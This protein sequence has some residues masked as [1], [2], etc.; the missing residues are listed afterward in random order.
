MVSLFSPTTAKAVNGASRF[1]QGVSRW[2]AGTDR[3]LRRLRTTAEGINALESAME[4]LSDAALRDKTAEFRDRLADGEALDDLLVEA[5]AV[6]REAGKRTLDQR[7]YDVQLMAGMVL[8]SGKI[9]EMRTGEGKTLVATLP[10]YLN[11]LAGN[12][13]HL[14][15]PNDYLSRI[16]G[17]WMG[18]VYD[19]L[20]ISVGVIAHEF[21]GLYD[22]DFQD[23]QQHGDPRLDHWR[24]VSRQE[25]YAADVTYGTNH[26]F[27]FDYLRDNMVLELS[28]MVQRPLYFAIV[29]EVDNILIDE[30]RT[31]LIISGPAEEPTD[32][33]YK[34]ARVVNSLAED[35][36][37]TVDLKLKAVSLTDEGIDRVEQQ[38]GVDNIYSEDNY[39][40][41]HYLEQAL[42]AKMLFQR[43]KEYVLF[44]DGRVLDGDRRDSNAEVVIVDEFTGRLMQ[45]R[46]Y[47]EGLHQAIE[48]K[49]G[50]RIQRENL[51]LATITFQNY[52]RLYDKLAGMTGTAVTEAEEFRKIYNLEVV[53]IPTHRPMIRDDHGDQV[54]KN[55]RA[56]YEAIIREIGSM[57]DQGR[58]VLVG[59]TSV[60]KS[61]QLSLMLKRRGISHQVLNA[62][63]HEG[64]ALVVAQAGS[65]G[66][67]TIATNMAGRGTDIIL[68]GNPP[69]LEETEAV[70]AAGGLHIVGTERHEARRIDN[71]LRGRAGRQGDSGSSRFYLSLDDDLMRRFVGSERIAG[72]I[73]HLGLEDDQPIE[74]GLVTKSIE[75]AQTKVEGYNFDIRKH[76]VEYDDVM[77]RQREVIYG[78]RRRLLDAESIS[79]VVS[80][81]IGNEIDK[82]VEAYLVLDRQDEWDLEGLWGAYGALLGLPAEEEHPGPEAS[83]F[84]HTLADLPAEDRS[85]IDG[86]LRDW[87]LDLA[88]A[89]DEL[90]GSLLM[91]QVQ[92]QVALQ[93]IDGLWVD[94]LTAIEDMKQ[95]IGLRAY[96][97]RDPLTEYKSEAYRMFQALVDDVQHNIVRALF[98]LPLPTS[99]TNGAASSE[100][101]ARQPRQMFTNSPIEQEPAHDS[102]RSGRR[103]KIGR[104][105]PCPCGSGKKYKR[106]HGR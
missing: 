74:H 34:F 79:E 69:N 5:F 60:E 15:T 57:Q 89:R 12:G 26:E 101:A 19:A 46:R 103:K 45:G 35:R 85:E 21:G 20:G 43:D 99:G 33:Y 91:A 3:Q 88:T 7:M 11:A 58:P 76:T 22:P 38:V 83:P 23:S 39:H 73:D 54:F 95:G 106:C 9:A 32:T 29:D 50:V 28:Q 59:T 98:H 10:L 24:Q 41:V 1:W 78:Q 47:S 65:R 2:V 44:R 87:A 30:A 8:H 104:N 81:L 13:C 97:Q 25:A 42:K 40:L 62:K 72:I 84:E 37:F 105:D 75:T 93:V 4:A 102:V 68:G 52:F 67:V 100:A 51:T 31:P 92:R 63:Q 6:V 18:P 86:I 53:Q 17:G 64:E 66:A 71:Q 94:H 77:N 55:E 56:K 48:A 16:G 14:V 80:D 90:V 82:L 61:E 49:E 36:D 70:R 27:G 96:G